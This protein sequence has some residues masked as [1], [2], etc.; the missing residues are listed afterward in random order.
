LTVRLL[1]VAGGDVIADGVAEDIFLGAFGSDILC[2]FADDHHQLA[3]MFHLFR[4][5]RQDD[6]SPVAMIEEGGL[7]KMSG[8][9]GT[10][11]PNSLACST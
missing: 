7:K 6:G 3:F 4:L 11:L 8:T 10:S 5:R 9:L 1:Q 2:A